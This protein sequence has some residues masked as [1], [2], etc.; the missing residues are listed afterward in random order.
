MASARSDLWT[1]ERR[2]A[3][4]NAQTHCTRGHAYAEVGRYKSGQCRECKRRYN[5]RPPVKRRRSENRKSGPTTGQRVDAQAEAI[6]TDRIFALEDQL[7]RESRQ[8]VRDEIKQELAAVQA[9]E[10][11]A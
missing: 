6:R 9:G 11:T 4:R 8:W 7:E 5:A 1:N 2:K 3:A 10:V